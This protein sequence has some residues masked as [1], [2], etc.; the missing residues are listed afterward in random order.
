[1]GVVGSRRTAKVLKDH[2]VPDINLIMT[3]GKLSE[4]EYKIVDFNLH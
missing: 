4:I 2:A 3:P 1:M